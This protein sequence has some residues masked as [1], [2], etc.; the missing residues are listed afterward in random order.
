MRK[1]LALAAACTA[2]LAVLAAPA[3]AA[4]TTTTFSVSSGLLSLST[5][6]TAV[7]LGTA[8]AT[9]LGTQVSAALAQVT[10]TDDRGGTTAWKT[11]VRTTDWVSDQGTPSDTSDDQTI[12]AT[13]GKMWVSTGPTVVSGT[14][15][16]TTTHIDELTALALS[17]T[18]QDFVSG[19]LV[20]GSNE[21]TYTPTIAVTIDSDTVA[22][23]YSG[24]ITQTVL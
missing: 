23:T 20:V 17:T 16:P 3:T 19:T 6:T 5:D 13:A 11:Q 12:P 14:V 10:V 4:D 9:A 18:A 24:T 22:G 15:T 2:A 1:I 21:V 7:D 8:T